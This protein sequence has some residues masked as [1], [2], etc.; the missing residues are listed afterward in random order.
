MGGLFVT[1]FVWDVGSRPSD[2][3]SEIHLLG[4]FLSG[5]KNSCVMNGSLD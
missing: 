1:L 2:W 3:Y 5:D 4:L